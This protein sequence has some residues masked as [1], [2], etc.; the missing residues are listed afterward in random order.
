[1]LVANTVDYGY[2]VFFQLSP[3]PL[4]LYWLWLIS[5]WFGDLVPGLQCNKLNRFK[6]AYSTFMGF[7]FVPFSIDFECVCISIVLTSTQ[8]LLNLLIFPSSMAMKRSCCDL[9]SCN[10]ICF[11]SSRISHDLM[12]H[13]HNI[14]SKPNVCSHFYSFLVSHSHSISE[15]TY[16]EIKVWVCIC[17]RAFAHCP[18]NDVMA[19]KRIYV[20]NELH[21][22]GLLYFFLIPSVVRLE[23]K[24]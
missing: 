13:F 1:M 15:C 2:L 16:F 22:F 5:Y 19:H 24:F 18:F 21:W 23:W 6:W 12:G 10:W 7:V 8:T 20:T 4:K 11:F 17:A 3:R 14:S 9:V